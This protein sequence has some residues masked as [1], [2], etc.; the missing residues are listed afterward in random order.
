MHLQYFE[1]SVKGFKSLSIAMNDGLFSGLISR[2]CKVIALRGEGILSG[3]TGST[4]NENFSRI[5]YPLC[6]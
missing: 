3:R 1:F 4:D 5:M 2:H 6:F